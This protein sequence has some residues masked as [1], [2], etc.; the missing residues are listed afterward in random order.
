MT[1]ANNYLQAIDTASKGLRSLSQTQ[2]G[3]KVGTAWVSENNSPYYFLQWIYNS[4]WTA[5]GYNYDGTPSFFSNSPAGWLNNVSGKVNSFFPAMNNTLADISA[6]INL[7]RVPVE[8]YM[9]ASFNSLADISARTNLI[10]QAV[11]TYIGPIFNNVVDASARIALVRSELLAVKDLLS[12]AD[13]AGASAR[14]DDIYLALESDTGIGRVLAEWAD[15][16]DTQDRVLMEWGTRWDTQ[17][18]VLM[19]WGK[20]WESY[21]DSVLSALGGGLSLD[22]SGIESRLDDIKGLLLAAGMAENAK[23]LLDLLIGDL[24]GIGQAAATGAIQGAMESAFPFCVPAV[25]KQVFGLLAYEGSAPVWEFDIC[26]NPLVCD[27][28]GFQLVADCTSWLSRI[29]LVLALL[30]NTR[31][32][33]FALN[34]GGSS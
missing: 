27:F 6:R 21:R 12:A 16:W 14:L 19:E 17:D 15:R 5:W 4:T 31:K 30:V 2:W 26:G 18:R 1:V 29:G 25:V 10:R 34:G 13:L 7:I 9:G 8:T 33:V 20:A 24:S 22:V 32:F 11:E 28:S 23:D 3:Y